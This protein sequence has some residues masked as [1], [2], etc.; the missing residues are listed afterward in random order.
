MTTRL[1]LAAL[2]LAAASAAHGA[3][4]AR[5]PDRNAPTPF[6]AMGGG[7]VPMTAV[8]GTGVEY[9]V[10]YLYNLSSSFG[11][12][13]LSNVQLSYDR[14][15]RE[16]FVTGDGPVRVFNDS[17]MET[18]T[19]GDDPEL[20]FVLSV[21]STE[22]GALV[23]LAAQAGRMA[24]VRCSFRGEFRGVIEPRGVPEAYAHLVPSILRYHDGKLYL[25]DQAGMRILVLDL[26]GNYVAGYDVAAKLNEAPRRDDLG[27]RGF[28]VDREGNILFTIQPLFTAYTMSPEGEIQAFGQRGSAP[29]KFNI[30]GGIARD[31]AGNYYV[32]D[33]LKSAVLV[34]DKDRV[35]R[36]EF[37]YRGPRPGNLAAPEDVV[38]VG[39]RVFVSQRARRGVSVFRVARQ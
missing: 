18:F 21:A 23:A 2:L 29:G 6:A 28:N 32:S 30:V 36:S 17:G 5:G 15:H 10:T 27:L 20:G 13:P 14:E 8:G 24:I 26:E 31:D 39:D 34:F 7:P 37:G 3:P 11:P 16:L 25:A 33:M 12:L 9:D 1:A 35:W 4:S 19:F 22:G 38:A